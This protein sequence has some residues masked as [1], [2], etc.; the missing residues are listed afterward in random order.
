MNISIILLV[1]VKIVALVLGGIVSL[2]AYRAYNR[3]RIAGLQFFAIGLAV[4]T[5]GTF[6]VG[7]FHHLGGASATIGMLLESVIISIGFVV[8]IY[9]LKQT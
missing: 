9:G 1:V 4:I 5:L 2:M 6:L 3:T 8:M 7:V